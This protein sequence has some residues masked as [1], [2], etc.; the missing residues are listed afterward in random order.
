MWLWDQMKPRNWKQ[1]L[2]VALQT[3]AKALT[4]Q[5]SD[6]YALVIIQ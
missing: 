4:K 1:P 5:A 2:L 6:A 3:Q